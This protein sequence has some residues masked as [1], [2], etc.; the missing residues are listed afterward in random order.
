MK[1]AFLTEIGARGKVPADFPNMRTEMAWMHALDADHYNVYTYPEVKGYD[2]V[3]IIFPK[4]TVNLNAVGGK[5]ADVPNEDSK[6]FASDIVEVLKNQNKKVCFVQEGPC[7]FF[8]EYSLVDQ[9]NYYNQLGKC[10]ILFAHNHE[11]EKWYRGLFPNMAVST[12][13]TLMI[14]T[15]TKDIIPNPENKVMI[16]GNFAHWYGGFQSYM[17]ASDLDSEMWVQTSH[18]SREGEDQIPDLKVLPRV[19]WIDWIRIL[20]TFKYGVNMMPTVAAGTFSLNC[21]YLGIPCIANKRLDTQSICHPKLS[22]DVEDVEYARFLALQLKHEEKF[23]QLCSDEAKEMYR[24][25]FS[26]DVFLEKMYKTLE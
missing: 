11:D 17:V 19:S 4:G 3:F 23:Y 25:H 21:A 7:W 18:A 5:I 8:N 2:A 10:D 6:L 14:E 16:G 15:L 24:K 9:F 22:V 13:P 12:I 20:S 26:K 1:I